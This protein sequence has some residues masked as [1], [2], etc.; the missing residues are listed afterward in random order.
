MKK[1]KKE[2]TEK[3]EMIKKYGLMTKECEEAL[4]R[5][6]KIIES[7]KKLGKS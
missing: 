5:Y 2:F 6:K 3:F 4:K 1:S 7:V